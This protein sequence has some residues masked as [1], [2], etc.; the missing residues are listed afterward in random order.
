MN[1]LLVACPKKIYISVFFDADYIVDNSS[2]GGTCGS[3]LPVKNSERC[4]YMV[5]DYDHTISDHG[6]AEINVRANRDDNI[7]WRA[8][9]FGS[10]KYSPHLY[11]FVAT[12]GRGNMKNIR[13]DSATAVVARPTADHDNGSPQHLGYTVKLSHICTGQVSAKISN[14]NSIVYHIRF[15]LVTP[16]GLGEN[17]FKVAGCYFWDSCISWG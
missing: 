10:G 12:G 6:S 1:E 9:D 14:K 7:I 17:D 2:T 8:L 3:P 11:Q 5:A 4:I 16:T 15:M 13:I